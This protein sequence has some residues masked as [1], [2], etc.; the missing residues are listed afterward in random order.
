MLKPAQATKEIFLEAV[1]FSY[2]QSSLE[3]LGNDGV[4]EAIKGK[5]P[6]IKYTTYGYDIS[7]L[8]YDQKVDLINILFG[9]REDWGAVDQLEKITLLVKD[10]LGVVAAFEEALKDLPPG[11]FEKQ[12]VA[13]LG[14]EE[15]QA[16]LLRVL[17]DLKKTKGDI[18]R[19][20]SERTLH[21]SVEKEVLATTLFNASYGVFALNL[22]GKI[23]TFNKE[24]E[25]LTGYAFEEVKGSLADDVV[26][27]FEDS[28]PLTID[29][30]APFIGVRADKNIY[31]NNKVTL[32][33]RNG[34]KRYVRLVGTIVA[35]GKRINLRGIVTLADIT[36]EVELE[37]MKLDFVSIAAHELRTP[38][39]AIR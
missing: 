39:T 20:V 28:V 4:H 36:K 2:L 32:V 37:N 9:L 3:M 27:L 6:K 24:M 34:S 33:A 11:V 35:E 21:L 8:S 5:F 18:E 10:R 25:E 13:L 15:L 30:Y 1:A 31:F 29:K 38:I 23:V 17:N 22:E 14:K 26:R 19:I 7:Q 12:K 16:E